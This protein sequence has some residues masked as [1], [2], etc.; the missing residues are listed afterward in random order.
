MSTSLVSCNNNA[1]ITTVMMAT[2]I[3]YHRPLSMSP[4]ARATAVA[5]K[6]SY[7]RRSQHVISQRQGRV[8]ILVSLG[9]SCRHVKLLFSP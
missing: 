7:R 5:S 3:G 1:P 9:I 4:V 6:G 2:T 8:T